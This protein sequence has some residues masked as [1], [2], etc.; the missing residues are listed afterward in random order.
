MKK[1]QA[2]QKNVVVNFKNKKEAIEFI[3][4]N[5]SIIT[6]KKTSGDI[7]MLISEIH[8]HVFLQS[9]EIL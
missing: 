6:K 7:T 2:V 8:Q 1:F 4:K 3:E 9:L 5:L